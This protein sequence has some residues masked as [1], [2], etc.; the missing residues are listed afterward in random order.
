M[1]SETVKE[2]LRKQS[3][4]LDPVRLLHGIR[5]LQATL[6]ALAKPPGSE[7]GQVP[8]S[9]SLEAFL[10]SLPRL[11]RQGEPRPTHRTK[12]ASSRTWRTR[13]DPFEDVWPEVLGWLQNE[14]ETTAKELLERLEQGHPGDFRSGQLRTLQRRVREWRHAIAM[15]L[16]Y[17]GAGE[18]GPEL[19]GTLPAV[20]LSG[21]I[22]K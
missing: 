12:P 11:W 7:H 16:I 20:I 4:A 6:C 13:T 19:E 22:P 2:S 14:P 21:N 18:V 1:V 10:A 17:A 3:R 15:E 9:Q 8:A 5:E